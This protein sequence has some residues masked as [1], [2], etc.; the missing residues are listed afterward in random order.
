M[1]LGP[2]MLK[3]REE[4]SPGEVSLEERRNADKIAALYEIF[5]CLEY[6]SSLYG[7]LLHLYSFRSIRIVFYLSLSFCSIYLF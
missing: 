7:I 6:T 5:G 2:M 3:R 4:L 1:Y